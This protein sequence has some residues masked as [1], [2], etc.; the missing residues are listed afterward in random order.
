MG[1]HGLQPNSAQKS[2]QNLEQILFSKGEL[3]GCAKDPKSLIHH[4]NILKLILRT[5]RHRASRR[6]QVMPRAARFGAAEQLALD[7]RDEYAGDPQMIKK[8]AAVQP[9]VVLR[10]CSSIAAYGKQP[11]ASQTEHVA[12]SSM[13]TKDRIRPVGDR[14]NLTG[15]ASA[16]APLACAGSVVAKVAN[17]SR[18]SSLS[19]EDRQRFGLEAAIPG[20]VS[21]AASS[22]SVVA[23]TMA[24]TL[25][26]LEAVGFDAQLMSLR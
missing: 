12:P 3:T 26:Q 21:A 18:Q 5:G 16:A 8:S 14:R 4:W 10:Q 11:A 6:Q 20:R 13:Y 7:R 17:V 1:R 9:H 22:P 15:A 19:T 23:P 2:R 25:A 24:R